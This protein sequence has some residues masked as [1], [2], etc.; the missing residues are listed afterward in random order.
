MYDLFK[1]K[2]RYLQ[3]EK[4]YKLTF[5]IPEPEKLWGY[6]EEWYT[7]KKTAENK[8]RL[9]KAFDRFFNNASFISLFLFGDDDE[10][11]YKVERAMYAY[12]ETR[13]SSLL[14][15]WSYK[16]DGRHIDFVWDVPKWF[17]TNDCKSMCNMEGLY[18]LVEDWYTCSDCYPSMKYKANEDPKNTLHSEQ[19]DALA[20]PSGLNLTLIVQEIQKSLY[21]SND[22][23]ISLLDDPVWGTAYSLGNVWFS[24]YTD[25]LL[26]VWEAPE[27]ETFGKA[28]ATIKDKYLLRE[29][30]SDSNIPATVLDVLAEDSAEEVRIAVTRNANTP[31]CTLKKMAKDKNQNVLEA[32]T[33]HPGNF[34]PLLEE[35]L[36]KEPKLILTN[37]LPNALLNV[38]EKTLDPFE[39]ISVAQHPHTPSHVLE[40]LAKD[41][42]A[43]VRFNVANNPNTPQ[44]LAIELLKDKNADVCVS[45]AKHSKVPQKLIAKLLTKQ[46]K[47]SSPE[48]RRFVAEGTRTPVKVLEMLAN[49]QDL[50]VRLRITENPNTPPQLAVALLKELATH[51]FSVVHAHVARNPLTPFA[52]RED[53]AKTKDHT[54]PSSLACNPSTPIHVLEEWAKNI[55]KSVRMSVACNPSTPVHVLEDLAKDKDYMVRNHLTKNP[56]TPLPMLEELSKDNCWVVRNHVGER[57][58]PDF[59]GSYPDMVLRSVRDFKPPQKITKAEILR[60]LIGF[61]YLPETPTKE[62]LAAAS[63]SESWLVRLAVCLHPDS[64]EEQLS[65]LTK[66]P[67]PNVSVAAQQAL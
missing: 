31:I 55:D 63:C 39:R 18:Y 56:N 5:D 48:V 60:A 2:E 3:Q 19:V 57:I 34:I 8:N 37:P 26:Q 13:D 58:R 62:D 50:D 16:R 23:S 7:Y 11:A 61:E 30:A 65:N 21:T 66:D 25:Q 42:I 4:K 36:K 17:E 43:W 67:D 44:H 1:F 29:I 12:E 14:G 10:L 52:V 35:L 53:L 49:D 38:L 40:I 6:F 33:E 24:S 47:S 54:M 46:A 27:W 41:P 20:Q 9:F 22:I 28:L 45:A 32:A 51:Q 59:V 64:T 15:D